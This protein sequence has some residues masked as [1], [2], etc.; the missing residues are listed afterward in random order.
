[1]PRHTVTKIDVAQ[2]TAVVALVIGLNAEFQQLSLEVKNH[3]IDRAGMNRTRGNI[4]N[5]MA[6]R[7]VESHGDLAAV[8]AHD[9]FHARAVTDAPRRRDHR[10]HFD[11][12]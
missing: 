3:L 5:P 12:C 2:L 10:R 7:H 11:T 4:D 6:L 1:M 8:L 9:E